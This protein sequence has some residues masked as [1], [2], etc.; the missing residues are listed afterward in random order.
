V[1]RK[2]G[3]RTHKETYL[4]DYE[5]GAKLRIELYYNDGDVEAGVQG[6]DAAVVYDA[7]ATM[8]NNNVIASNYVSQTG[9]VQ[10]SDASVTLM[11]YQHT[12]NLEGLLR[13]QNG[14]ATIHCL[15]AGSLFTHLTPDG[16]ENYLRETARTLKPGPG[17]SR[18][19][20]PARAPP[21]P[22]RPAASPDCSSGCARLARTRRPSPRARETAR[23]VHAA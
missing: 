15:F 3:E 19:P 4:M 16:T 23:R 7:T 22:R 8:P 13:R 11:D 17:A 21:P 5:P 2:T 18:R 20:G 1:P 9:S 12:P 6:V 10:T 14:T